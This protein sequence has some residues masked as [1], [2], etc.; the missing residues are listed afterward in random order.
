MSNRGGV[1]FGKVADAIVA[2][3]IHLAIPQFFGQVLGIK[4]RPE[5]EGHLSIANPIASVPLSVDATL[6]T[7]SNSRA[8]RDKKSLCSLYIKERLL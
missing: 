7:I 6:F 1:E 5:D 3:R 4:I 8:M 2:A